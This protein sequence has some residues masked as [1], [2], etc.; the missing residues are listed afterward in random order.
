MSDPF[1]SAP[2]L[3]VIGQG[4][5][6]TAAAKAF[7]EADTQ[8][9]VSIISAESTRC[10]S[11]PRL[12]E[13]VAGQTPPE[14]ICLYPE[15]WY[16]SQRI[17]LILGR[18]ATQID[19]FQRRI[20]LDDGTTMAY[21]KAVLATGAEATWPAIAGLPSPHVLVLRT[22]ED[23]LRLRTRAQGKR[24]ALLIGGGLLGLEA[25]FAL[26]KLGLRVTVLEAFPR[27]LP[28]QVD[29]E[30]S[31]LLQSCLAPIG[32]EF[33]LGSRIESI[34]ADENQVD[35]HLADGRVCRGELALISAGIMPRIDLAK[36][37]GLTV[38]RGIVV[39]D[40]LKTSAEDIWAAGDVAEWRGQIAGLWP[41]A[42]A[43]GRIA[44]LN[45][46]GGR[47]R[48]QGWVPSPKLKVAGVDLW[49]QG[50]I[51]PEGAEVL[52]RSEKERGTLTK[53]FVR[54]NRLA[55]SIQIGRSAGAV[56]YKRLIESGLPL[57]DAAPEL[58]DEG[59]DF[60]RIPGFNA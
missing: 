17:R 10:Y 2:G 57:G 21:S 41:A 1:S 18:S 30:G 20:D 15:S 31:Q 19:P 56:Q 59:F 52:A 4:A 46:A 34:R 25:G 12:P 37:S 8:T 27:L 3:V 9:P 42:Q 22:L 5:A 60:S 51:N 58:L 45:A 23:A 44:G 14:N 28:R 50:N 6:G 43:M 26:T 49:S 33:I 40:N 48:Y 39:D 35:L 13:V 38:Q 16:A 24:Q 47:E 54:E 32:F 11:R 55:G 29:D 7:R 36:H 53:L